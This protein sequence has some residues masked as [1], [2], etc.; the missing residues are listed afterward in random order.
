MLREA[1]YHKPCG[2]YAYPLD[3]QT[4]SIT[5]RAKK[6]DLKSCQLFYGDS[7][8]PDVPLQAVKM[9]KVATDELFD[10]FRIIVDVPS[11]RI[12]YVF[13]LDDGHE[14]LWYSEKGFSI[15]KFEAGELGLPY[16]ELLY[17]REN[18]VF[19][20]PEWARGAVIYQIFPDRFY[21][22]DKTNDPPNSKRW[23]ELPVTE[24][25]FYGGDLRGIIEKISYLSELGIDAIY[26]TPIFSSPSPHKYDTSDY[27]QIDPHFG[28]FETFKELVDKCHERNIKVIL[29]GVFDHCGYNFWAFQDVVQKG[30]KSKYRKWFRIYDFPIRTHPQ[31]TY[32]TWGK[33]IWWMPRLLTENPEVKKY[34][35]K[36]AVYWIE[37]AGIDGWRLD[38][39]SEVDHD[40]WREF[41]KAVK[42]A[43]P[44]ALLIGEVPHEVTP[45][46]QGDQFDSVMNYPFRAVMIDFFAKET[47]KVDVFD[48]ILAKQRVEY[49]QQANEVL[50]NLLGSHDT[51]RFLSLCKGKEEKMVLAITFQMTY[52]GM[53]A[54]YYGDEVG[55]VG[56]DWS[57]LDCRRAMV[58]DEVSQ[59]RELL[60]HYKKLINIRK[61]HPALTQGDFT[62]VHMNPRSNTYGF[63]RRYGDER[64][65]VILNNSPR[66]QTVTISVK[67]I[68]FAENATF[69]DL[70]SREEHVAVDGK[71][72]LH[73]SRYTSMILEEKL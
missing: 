11:R 72:K 27:Y 36:V 42:R 58:W 35:I 69:F 55:M 3:S 20:V 64:I 56:G 2:A 6:G 47:I 7:W 66:K 50:Y 57:Y 13:L 19:S 73:L 43:N 70:L 45:W 51:I 25:T 28:D 29:D 12:R 31:P 38:V 52:L 37:K 60:N 41:R 48:A 40:F 5:L 61:V 24:D 8:Q 4:L 65:F 26:L 68:G 17:I 32:E 49:K 63:L 30:R 46:L 71:M 44:E 21:N 67:K 9:K 10:Y 16:F 34:L 15:E 33:G 59:N 23:G 14:K 18:D 54:I 39:A 22:A 62:T 1:I 53:P